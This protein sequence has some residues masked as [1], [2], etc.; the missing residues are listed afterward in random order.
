MSTN[1]EVK[2]KVIR[3]TLI[4]EWEPF[5]FDVKSRSF[6]VKNF[7]DGPCY[8]S[9]VD[10]DETSESIKI[11]SGMAEVCYITMLQNLANSFAR[12]TIYVYGTGEIEVE[13]IEWMDNY[14]KYL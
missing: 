12:D 9:F 3:K 4:G 6:C 10:D 2:Q 11:S 8:V 7:S 14:G 5:T 1:E 13:A